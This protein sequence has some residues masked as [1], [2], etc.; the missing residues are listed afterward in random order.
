MFDHKQLVALPIL[1]EVGG[2]APNE[3]GGGGGGSSDC[4]LG[5]AGGAR[6]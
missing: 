5:G 6:T 4:P 3:R 1:A 2:G